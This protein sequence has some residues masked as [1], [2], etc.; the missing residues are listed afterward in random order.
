MQYSGYDKIS[1]NEDILLDLPF[2]EGVGTETFDH[3]KLHHPMTFNDPGGGSFAWN[4]LASGLSVLEFVTVGGGATDGVY[5][6]SPAADTADL[7]F[8]N[9]DFSLAAWIKWTWN[10]Q[11]SIVFGRYGVNL[12][13]WEIYLDI[14]GGLNT[15]SQRHHH[16]SLAPNNNSNCFSTGWTPGTYAF[17]GISRIGG[18]LYPIHYR[19]GGML[20]MSYETSGMLDP[21][22][23]N[24]DLVLGCRYTKDANWYKGELSRPRVW[25]RA[26]SSAE[27]LTL[28]NRERD[29]FG[30]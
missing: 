22:T 3:A 9:G 6:D 1:E 15:V 18:D 21:D 28:F 13:G 14:S 24:R 25:E 7:D 2:R 23:C 29:F 11:S 19:N 12:D 4:T 16:S 26:L 17:L 30:V 5:L 8:T 20:R 10:G 27:W